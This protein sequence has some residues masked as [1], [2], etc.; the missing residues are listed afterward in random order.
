MAGRLR[1]WVLMGEERKKSM[2]PK[3]RF[4]E[5]WESG[6]WK[7]T[8]LNKL[9]KRRVLKNHEGKVLRVL[10]N[11]AEH[12]VVDQL[13][14]FDKDIAVQGNLKGYFVVKNGDFVYNPRISSFA[15]VG[16]ISKNNIG[17]G[18][19][20]P[21]YT[22]FR[23]KVEDDF[24][25]HYFKS[26]GWHPYMRQ[27]S[28][29]GARHDRMAISKDDFESMPLPVAPM[30]KEQ[31]KIADC[32]T[33]LDELITAEVDK[34]EAYKSHKRGLMQK[35]FPSEGKTVPEWRF[36][37]FRGKGEWRVVDLD[38]IVNDFIVPMRDKPKNLDGTIPWCRIEDFNGMYLATSKSNQGVSWATVK[39]MNLKVYPIH[40]LLVSCSADLGRCVITQKELVTNQTFIGLVPDSKKVNIV[41]LYFIM[42]NSRN[43]LNAR[44]SGTT[45]SYLSRQEFEKF[46]IGLPIP[47]EQQKIA[48]CLSSL[49]KLITAQ[50]QKIET[51]KTHKK[52]LMQGLFPS[53]DEV[54]V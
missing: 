19:M 16:P 49:D 25:A 44:S 5:F 3:W 50:T 7:Y 10:T 42:V 52:G 27:I 32:L 43:E 23:F 33:S 29:T 38:S 26:T 45:I 15:P 8:P 46:K 40:T 14:Y 22:I 11:S 47:Q 41:Y 28:S 9:A 37:E 1:G 54:G 48:D 51:L 12:G 4:P 6:E 18:V 2:V 30:E 20:S 24:Y 21:L 35:L 53:A 13:D 34:L 17:T 31:Q 36:P 39:E